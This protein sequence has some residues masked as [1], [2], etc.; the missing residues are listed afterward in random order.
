M[1]VRRRLQ[2][3]NGLANLERGSQR[4]H[5]RAKAPS[6]WIGNL[7][8]HLPEIAAA[9]KTENTSPDIIEPDRNDG[10]VHA[11][12]DALKTAAERKHLSDAR[13]LPFGEDA[14]NVTGLDCAGGCAERMDQVARALLGGNRDAA[15]RS[16]EGMNRRM[17]VD[18]LPPQKNGGEAGGAKPQEG[19][20]PAK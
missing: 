4:K 1:N 18:R 8:W 10:S 6:D 12:H 19:R 5:V 15:H 3:L 20:H 13:H 17:A 7:A 2:F 11:F 9:L 14:D 16:R